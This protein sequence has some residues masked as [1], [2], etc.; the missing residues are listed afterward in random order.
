MTFE[1]PI[2][3][4]Q[5]L[6]GNGSLSRVNSGLQ[7]RQINRRRGAP[8]AWPDLPVRYGTGITIG[9]GIYLLIGV[10]A[11]RAGPYSAWSFVLAAIVMIKPRTSASARRPPDQSRGTSLRVTQVIS[12]S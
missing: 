12:E 5:V 7:L 3:L 4:L 10:V 1:K 6:V 11:G 9:A 2:A 8:A